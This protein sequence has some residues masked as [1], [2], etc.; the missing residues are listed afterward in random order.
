[1]PTAIQRSVL[2]VYAAEV[3]FFLFKFGEAILEPTLRVYIYEAVCFNHFPFSDICTHL[4]LHPARELVVQHSASRFIMYYKLLLNCPAM[5]MVLFCGAWSDRYGRKLPVMLSCF[6]TTFA[7]LL[8][9]TSEQ[10]SKPSS[11]VTT[12]CRALRYI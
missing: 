7:V 9:M 2:G 5:I 6:G 8:Y 4:H 1:M 10:V 3:I 12:V 11:G